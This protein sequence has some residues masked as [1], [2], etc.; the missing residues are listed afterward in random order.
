MENYI[1]IREEFYSIDAWNNPK[2]RTKF[3]FI[4]L[5]AGAG[6]LSCGLCMAGFNPVGSVEIMPEAVLTYRYNFTTKGYSDN[7]ES[8]DI[9]EQEMKEEMKEK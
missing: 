4:D 1:D 2:D 9:R 5:F 7:V 6:G 3:N 8:R